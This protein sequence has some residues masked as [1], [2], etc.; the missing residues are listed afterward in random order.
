MDDIV[1][2]SDPR[3]AAIRNPE[4]ADVP[5]VDVGE[6][7]ALRIDR[8]KEDAVG[9]WRKVRAPI[10]EMLRQASLRAAEEGVRL[11][12]VEGYRPGALQER[13]FDEYVSTLRLED[14]SRDD[15]CLRALAARH[16]SPPEVAPHTAGAAVDV[17]L[18]R[19][20]VELDLGS[21]VNATPEESAGRCYTDHPGVVGEAAENRRLLI[22]IMSDAG[23]VNYPTEW[24]HWSYGD[25]YWAWTTGSSEALFGKI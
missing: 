1:L 24:W 25:R 8:R 20:G 10:A 22:A 4:T 2:L 16:V 23:F 12:L 6:L 11:R 17:T 15:A 14:P 13:Y 5:L 7:A 3:I 21:A 9:H 18:E 19:N